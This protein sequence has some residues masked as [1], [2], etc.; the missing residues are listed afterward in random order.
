MLLGP[1]LELWTAFELRKLVS[2]AK[3]GADE[4]FPVGKLAR[5]VYQVWTIHHSAYFGMT[6]VADCK[7][8]AGRTSAE[9]LSAIS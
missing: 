6:H 4:N 8:K 1:L 2:R 9:E 7:H 5:P 3:T